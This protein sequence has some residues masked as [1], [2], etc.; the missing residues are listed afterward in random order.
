MMFSDKAFAIWMGHA[1]EDTQ[2][3]TQDDPTVDAMGFERTQVL[4]IVR[5]E[6]VVV[7]TSARSRTQAQGCQPEGIAA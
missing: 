5:R 6:A 7:E 1:G 4:A 3:F 2:V